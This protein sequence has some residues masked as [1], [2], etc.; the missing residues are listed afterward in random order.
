[1]SWSFICNWI[2]RCQ[3]NISPEKSPPWG[4]RGRVRVRLGIGLG[5]ESGGLFSGGIFPRTE[6]LL[7]GV[8]QG[9]DP[10]MLCFA[11]YYGLK[12]DLEKAVSLLFYFKLG[13][14]ENRVKFEE[15]IEVIKPWSRYRYIDFSSFGW[16]S[17]V[18][19]HIVFCDIDKGLKP[20][21]ISQFYKTRQ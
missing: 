21:L 17:L 19:F 13:L 1:M 3:E 4:D 8:I 15:L 14:I 2:F 5:L 9:P 6:F 12:V 20:K 16:C 11:F 7:L 18:S 10:L